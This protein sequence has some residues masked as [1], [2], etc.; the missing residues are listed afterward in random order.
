M[1]KILK[2]A[3]LLG[4]IG[5]A[6]SLSAHAQVMG[7][8]AGWV[9]DSSSYCTPA[10]STL[11]IGST[12]NLNPTFN[13]ALNANSNKTTESTELV[14]L[15]P[16]SG[17]SGLNSLSFDVTFTPS[18]GGPSVTMTAT[19]YSGMGGMP[20]TSS[21]GGL[22]SYLGLTALNGT[23]AYQFNN[24]NALQTVGGTSA[25]TA[26]LVNVPMGLTGGSGYVTVSFSN[27]SSGSGFPYGTIFLAYGNDASG[28]IIYKTPLTD[29]LQ[30]VP[31]PM[32]LGLF[33]TGLLGIALMVRRRM[34][35]E[36]EA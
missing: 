17:T 32:T 26:Y 34:R 7:I 21:S 23:D 27:F 18:G 3:A 28:N 1:A 31:E 13:I 2:F 22:V 33:G 25:Y 19:A 29:G 9:P 36:Q 35:K 4:L 14:I 24:I 30:T 8:C 10:S 15:I 5:F 20:F 16:Q 11:D 6:F 12:G